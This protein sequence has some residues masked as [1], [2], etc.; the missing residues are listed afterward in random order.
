MAVSYTHLGKAMAEAAKGIDC[1]M[2]AVLNLD[3]QALA[4][5]CEQAVSYTHLCF[6]DHL[7]AGAAVDSALLHGAL[8][9]LPVL[10]GVAHQ[11]SLI[12]IWKGSAQQR[13]T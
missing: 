7:K 6:I 13:S 4:A 2:T 10:G 3:R 5:C 9:L 11:L 12:H 1:G 8:Q